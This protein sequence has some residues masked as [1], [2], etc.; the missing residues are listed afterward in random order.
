GLP[1]FILAALLAGS[2][3]AVFSF[4]LEAT[5]ALAAAGIIHFVFGRYCNF[6]A[7]RALG[8]N[9]VGPLQQISLI[10]TLVLAVLVLGE[11]LT[12][13]RILGIVLVVF[14]PMLTMG[15]ESEAQKKE[16]PATDRAETTAEQ[17]PSS[18]PPKFE[19]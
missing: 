8:S 1:L 2:L 6:R 10:V 4:S 17:L 3:G 13:L 11:A 12:P 16:P 14:G 19:I 5:I 7:T 9:L 18:A 15:G